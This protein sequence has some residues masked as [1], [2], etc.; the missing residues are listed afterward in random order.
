MKALFRFFSVVF[1]A[2]ICIALVI[3]TWTMNPQESQIGLRVLGIAFSALLS[4]L[5]VL[6]GWS[7]SE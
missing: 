7:L 6:V 1:A 3:E 5:I 2:V 4:S